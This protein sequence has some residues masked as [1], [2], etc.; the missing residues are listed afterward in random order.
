MFEEDID[1]GDNFRVVSDL[2]RGLDLDRC[3]GR[4]RAIG[5]YLRV[6]LREIERGYW[7]VSDSSKGEGA[8]Y[9]QGCDRSKD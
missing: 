7:R 3:H 2:Q 1:I 5:V 9:W 8:R 6:A 4:V